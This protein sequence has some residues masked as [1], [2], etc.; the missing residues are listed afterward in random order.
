MEDTNRIERYCMEN[1]GKAKILLLQ[2]L[3]GSLD[4]IELAKGLR[5]KG[6]LSVNGII[7]IF[8]YENQINDSSL[9]LLIA[10]EEE[11]FALIEKGIIIILGN[12]IKIV[13]HDLIMKSV[14]N[15]DN[16]LPNPTFYM[17]SKTFEVWRVSLTDYII[18]ELE[19][20]KTKVP[21][22]NDIK[23]MIIPFFERKQKSRNF[24]FLIMTNKIVG[25][26][27]VQY[28]QKEWKDG[29]EVKRADTSIVIISKS[30]E[31][32]LEK[33]KFGKYNK[34]LM[35]EH[36]EELSLISTHL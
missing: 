28:A 15:I 27:L 26:F 11:Y 32:E 4:S 3:D 16:D 12:R 36:L 8:D 33:F 9:L 24:I 19:R 10:C 23:G 25:D 14:I 31:K 20:L 29:R 35:N 21:K 17:L 6:I 7:R 1:K 2:E 13:P 5:R 34:I 30:L 22:F 18:M